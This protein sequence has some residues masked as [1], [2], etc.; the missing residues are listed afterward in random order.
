MSIK[1][2]DTIYDLVNNSDKLDGKDSSYFHRNHLTNISDL[3]KEIES[4]VVTFD[5]NSPTGGPG[6][7]INGFVSVHSN[8]LSSFIT[9]EHR[10][11]NWNV[12][13]Y[14]RANGS[15]T[16]A[17]RKLI[18]SGNIGSQSVNYANSA[19]AI[20]WS[21]VS[22]KPSTFTPSSHTHTKSQITDFSHD[23]N[24]LYVTSLSTSN[25]Y[26]TWTKNGITNN[27]TIPYASNSGTVG[28]YE[29]KNLFPA[30]SLP[31]SHNTY[32]NIATITI[33]QQGYGIK[34]NIFTGYGYNAS[35]DQSR[36]ATI[37]IRTSNG[38]SSGGYYYAGY[39]DSG[40]YG[41][42]DYYIVQNSSTSFTLWG[43]KTYYSGA[44][45]YIIPEY[46]NN[47]VVYT[48]SGTE[49]SSLPSEAVKL[50]KY[51]IAYT[52]FNVASA[53]KLSTP[54]TISFTGSV[55]G[56]GSFDG[57]GN[58]SI[59]TTTNHSHSN[60]II[61]GNGT[62]LGTYTGAS[63]ITVNLTYSNVG[64]ASS[65]H[66]HLYAGSTSAGG[67]A[68]NSDKVDGYHISSIV[69]HI[70]D[71][72]ASTDVAGI[73]VIGITGGGNSNLGN[74]WGACLQLCNAGALSAKP[75]E[76][77]GDSNWYSQL[78]LTTDSR[79]RARFRT[80]GGAWTGQ[81][82]L[83]YTSDIPT[84][85]TSL[86]CPTSLTIQANG[87][88]LGSYDG[89]S[90]KT[91]NITYSN[92][93]AAAAS[94]SHDYAA[95]SHSHTSYFYDKGNKNSSWDTCID[96]GAFYTSN[97]TPVSGAYG[98]GTFL[99]FRS[100]P[101]CVQFYF[102]DWSAMPYFRCGWNAQSSMSS[103]GWVGLITTSNIGS[104]SVNYASSSGN[105]DTCDSHHFSTV[106]SLPSSPDANTVYFIV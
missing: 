87:T 105:S 36:V 3:T 88:S 31:S 97:V 8:Y 80:N 30:Y 35:N 48:H 72:N 86:K 79:V 1:L 17:W 49:A 95:S 23:H 7:W 69:K 24:S 52:D 55:T 57:S 20:A 101:T 104:Q 102:P 90:A 78:I 19:G 9:N 51:Q 92:V 26:L 25:N 15:G 44:G 22:G 4:N 71:G 10:T 13:Y 40:R 18:H 2:K 82:T 39:V 41:S 91:F 12:G 53:N 61:Q 42:Y 75:S 83:A 54:R 63:A 46:K 65:G 106:S 98:Y 96:N 81:Y 64:A 56:S 34:L 21:N 84:I 58:L 33:P 5:Y 43:D 103:Y 76:R 66:T 62:N 89:S 11:D 28:G 94:H 37:Y 68:I 32:I 59:A 73:N 67:D 60:L 99:A 29:A 77:N 6:G 74:G 100:Y 70:G 47:N 27:I 93:G 16:I 38:Q 45:C 50:P 85:P 14:D